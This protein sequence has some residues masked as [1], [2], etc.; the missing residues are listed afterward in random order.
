MSDPTASGL[1]RWAL[2]FGGL[3]FFTCYLGQTALGVVQPTI[4]ADLDLSASE[5]QWVVNSFFLTLALFAAPGGRLGDY[6]GHREVLL[7]AFGIFTVGALLAAVSQGF[8]WLILGIAVSGAGAST[9][10]PAS[11]AM[12]ANRVTQEDR[13][14]A[15]GV[16]SAIGASVFTLGP[17]LAGLLTEAIDWR[18]LFALEAA[19]GAALLLVGLSRVD[20]RPVGQ[21]EPFDSRGLIL[22][23]TSLSALLVGLMQALA[24]GLLAPPTLLLLAAGLAGVATFAALELRTRYPLLD[25]G[26]LRR[27][28]LRGIVLAMFTAQ[29]V[30]TGF[31]VY[32]VTYFQHILDYGPLVASL[33]I[34]P[35]VI[36]QPIFNVLAGRATDRIGMRRPALCG[37]LLTAVALAWIAIALDEES[38]ALLL[39]GLLLMGPG[40]APMFTSL[41]TGLANAVSAE[42]R[43]D[44]NALVLTVRWIGA[45]A[46]TMVLGL[47][48]HSGETIV[49]S[50]TPYATAMAILS[51]MALLG[52]LACALL[53]RK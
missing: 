28:T 26:L 32:L 43:G 34:V 20:N 33:A 10:Y 35:A 53:L 15:I 18:A 36:T 49:P 39:P 40:V 31:I 44:A 17:V 3:A 27:R 8:V 37:Y 13:G 1:S 48:I 9:L 5:A 4:A 12:I 11:A 45:A 29:F 16:Y 22:L 7:F 42:E 19:V 50:A 24:W 2:W 6:Y 25:V 51:A 47:V 41:L 46:G 38:Y 30:I 21:P 52:A 14:R 23:M